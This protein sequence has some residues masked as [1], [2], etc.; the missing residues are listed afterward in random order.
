MNARS[1]WKAVLNELPKKIPLSYFDMFIKPLKISV[2]S[3][4]NIQLEAPSHLIKNHVQHKYLK[5]IKSEFE[6]L[7]FQNNKIEVIA[8]VLDEKEPKKTSKSKKN[9]AGTNLYT[10]DP[11]SN[12]IKLK[13]CLFSKY[14]FKRDTIEGTIY[15]KPKNNKKYF[16]LTDKEFNGILW[17]LRSTIEFKFVTKNL[18]EEFLYSPFVPEEHKFKDYLESIK[19]LWD[20]KTDYF[21]KLCECVKVDNE[22]D[23]YHFFKKW[24]KQSIYYG[25]ARHLEKEY[26]VPE[27]VF[28]IQGPGFHYKTTFLKSLIPDEIK[29]LL[30]YSDFHNKQEKDILYLGSS[31]VYWLLDEIDR[32]LKGAKTSELRNFISRSGG[33]ERAAYAKF[34][35]EYT[36]ICSIF[37]ALNPTEFLSE[38]ETGNRRFLIF[39]I[40][41]PIDI[42]KANTIN[43]NLIY[44]Q[45][46][47][48]ILKSRNKK[49]IYWT[50]SENRLIVENNFRYNYSSH[51]KE[52][53]LKYF[54]PIKKEDFDK[55]NE[56]HKSLNSTEIMEFI[57]EIHP[58][59]NLYI[60]TIGKTMQRL[61]FYQN[62]SHKVSRSYLVSLNNK[63]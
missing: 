56:L 48:E 53:I 46:Y 59:L 34:H 49:D 42:D 31:K 21:K 18:L 47:N 29:S 37:G 28:L 24:F 7:N 45:L 3:S 36:R 13:D 38:D 40:K 55:N 54:S 9:I 57:L 6:K 19:N 39:T 8:S 4:G 26:N 60:R 44:S 20:G 35:T 43:K 11:N 16:K 25:Y 12:Y 1:A 10:I 63:D 5:E 52:L 14:D 15:F 17:F 32:Y 2:D 22:I 33:T 23:F 62:K 30:E 41:N 51:H 27:T 50:Q 58:K 61:G